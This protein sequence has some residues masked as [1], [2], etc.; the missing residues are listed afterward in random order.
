MHTIEK[1]AAVQVRVLAMGDPRPD[2]RITDEDVNRLAQYY[3]LRLSI[4]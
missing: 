3:G 1:A 2:Q 4:P